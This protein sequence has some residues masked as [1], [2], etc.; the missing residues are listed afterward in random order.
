M[1]T[2]TCWQDRAVRGIVGKRA[3]CFD[4]PIEI[5]ISTTRGNAAVHAVCDDRPGR[6]NSFL[7][8]SAHVFL[9]LGQLQKA[10]DYASSAAKLHPFHA[11]SWAALDQV[12]FRQSG[13]QAAIECLREGLKKVPGSRL[14]LVG[15]PGAVPH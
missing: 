2:L 1:Q 13:V 6:C 5:E 8:C 14:L 10:L 7:D 4:R 3:I 12:L 11:E 9:A 15:S